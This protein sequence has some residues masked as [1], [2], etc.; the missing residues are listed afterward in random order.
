MIFDDKVDYF[1][2]VDYSDFTD[3]FI[4]DINI[5]MII[6]VYVMQVVLIVICEYLIFIIVIKMRIKRLM[7]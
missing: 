4:L 7:E 6:I 1:S 5:E 2:T 3:N